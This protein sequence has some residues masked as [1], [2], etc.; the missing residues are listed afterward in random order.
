VLILLEP[1]AQNP[2]TLAVALPFDDRFVVNAIGETDRF[3]F[4][5]EAG[6]NYEIRV[7]RN[8]ASTLAGEARVLSAGGAQ[9]ASGGFANGGFA[10][11]VASGPGGTMSVEVTATAE[12]P[13]GYR[14]QIR[15]VTASSCGAP[16]AVTLPQTSNPQIAAGATLCFDLALQ[17]GDAIRVAAQQL[18]QVSGVITLVAPDGAA[19][20]S[21]GYGVGVGPLLLD[22]GV[23]QSG[24]WQVQ[25]RN[26][27]TSLGTLQ[28]LAFSRL[29]LDGTID[30]GGSA[31]HSGSA[32]TLPRRYLVRPGTAT[33]V[34]YKLTKTGAQLYTTVYPM[35]SFIDGTQTTGRVLAHPPALLPVVLVESNAGTVDFTL[36]TSAPETMSVDTDLAVTSPIGGDV[37]FWRVDGAAGTQWTIGYASTENLQTT[38][39]GPDG[40]RMN[41]TGAALQIYT[42]AATGVHTVELRSGS[43]P[44]APLTVRVNTAAPP[45]PLGLGALTQRSPTLAIGEVR[46]YAFD[47]TRGQLLGL[48]MTTTGLR[49]QAQIDGG[50]IYN[51]YVTVSPPN[52]LTNHSGPLYVQQNAA[53]VL[54]L[55]AASHKPGEASGTVSL[56][57]EAPTPTPAALGELLSVQVP[58]S[59]LVDWRYDIAV[60]GKHL[61]CY[62]YTGAVD[63]QGNTRIY[64]TVWGPVA[65]FTNYGGDIVGGGQGTALETL[66][67]LSVGM[68]TL[69]LFNTLPS[70]APATARLVPIAPATTLAVGASDSGSIATCQR[71]Y[72]TFAAV[73]GQSYTVK[74]TA[75]FAGSVRVRKVPPAGDVTARA[76]P[77]F[78]DANLGGTPLG[79]TAGV[80][81]TVTFTI[82]SDAQHGSGTYIV[83]IDANGDEAGNYTVSLTSP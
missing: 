74:V 82:P 54:S 53:A 19:A 11:V 67:D 36:Q 9:L 66:G 61:L 64:G 15:K 37:R 32:S 6:A 4:G 75:A 30:L 39:Y 40:Q 38:L 2:G 21:R 10:T 76:D 65:R 33:A 79:L 77:P 52:Q 27:G 44:A 68:N 23:A 29:A 43:G 25:I 45:E 71:R 31:S 17:A 47:V 58:P 13:G 63:T 50:S 46:R 42:L 16:Q 55:W 1:V 5:A 73:T 57:I 78:S 3:T 41:G 48:R 12:A 80:E 20:I 24:T 28:G 70:S 18:S 56:D 22:T 51:G 34:A 26:T 72:H 81:R 35:G 49:G 8:I 14:V 62:S 59:T 69:T 7:E 83:E 60:A